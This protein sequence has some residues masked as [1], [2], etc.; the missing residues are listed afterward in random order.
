[1]ATRSFIGILNDDKTVDYI[2]CHYDGYPEHNGVVLHDHYNDEDTVR[3]LISLGDLSSLAPKISAPE[4]VEHSFDNRV[5]DVCV[6]YGRDRGDDGVGYKKTTVDQYFSD[7]FGEGSWVDYLY[8]FEPSYG[9]KVKDG[10]VPVS[11]MEF[12]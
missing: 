9:W 2:Y 1:M 4:G 5:N 11:L 6:F 3:D 10:D 8:L 7:N 12:I